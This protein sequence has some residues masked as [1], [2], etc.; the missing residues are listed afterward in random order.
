MADND[1]SRN[2]VSKKKFHRHPTTPGAATKTEKKQTSTPRRATAYSR[3]G[4]HVE[5]SKDYIAKTRKCRVKAAMRSN[6][7]QRP[8]EHKRA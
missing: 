4:I 1:Y 3:H 7:L 5:Q 2:G 8:K 6:K